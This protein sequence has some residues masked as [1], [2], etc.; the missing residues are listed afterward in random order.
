LVRLP[1]L[2]GMWSLNKLQHPPRS[3][4]PAA[5][6]ALARAPPFLPIGGEKGRESPIGRSATYI[7]FLLVVVVIL[8]LC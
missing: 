7:D 8:P 6:P 3:P 2:L 1:K 5:L 4:L